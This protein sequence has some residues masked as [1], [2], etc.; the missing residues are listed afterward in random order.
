MADALKRVAFASLMAVVMAHGMVAEAQQTLT[1]RV[2]DLTGNALLENTRTREILEYVF[3]CALPSDTQVHA[4]LQ[5]QEYGFSGSLGIAPGW[6]S[7]PLTVDQQAALTACLLARTN[8][9]GASVRISLRSFEGALAKLP[10]LQASPQEAQDFPVWEGAFFGNIFAD[11]PVTYAC[12]SSTAP[13]IEALLRRAKRVCT[14]PSG[15]ETPD[16][17]PMSACGFVI[18]GTCSVAAANPQVAAYSNQT[19]HV[20][21][22]HASGFP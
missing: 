4:E 18:L 3:Q 22:P 11:P 20:Y 19:I 17:Q 21:L 1:D 7:G 13:E 8:A 16:G 9:F 10:A 6:R 5:G 14:L 2:V 15:Q 12:R